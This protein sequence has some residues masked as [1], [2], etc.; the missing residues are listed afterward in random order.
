MTRYRFPLHLFITEYFAE[1]YETAYSFV[2]VMLV[3]V[4]SYVVIFQMKLSSG[5][6]DFV[7]HERN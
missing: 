1:K 7:V 5:P 3:R 4:I 6:S 2:L